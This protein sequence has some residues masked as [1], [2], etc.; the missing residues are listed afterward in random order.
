MKIQEAP[1][2]KQRLAHRLVD[3]VT[4]A[5][6]QVGRPACTGARYSMKNLS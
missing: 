5:F 4:L 6:R 3:D 2:Y 1:L